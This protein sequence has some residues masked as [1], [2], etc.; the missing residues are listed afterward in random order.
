MALPVTSPDDDGTRAR[1]IRAARELRLL[2]MRYGIAETGTQRLDDR[3][4]SHRGRLRIIGEQIAELEAEKHRLLGE[5]EG[6]EKALLLARTS[7][8]E[9]LRQAHAEAWSPFGIRAY[10]VWQIRAGRLQGLR[11]IWE[12]PELTAECGRGAGRDEVPHSDGRCGPPACGIYAAKRPEMLL[13]SFSLAFAGAMGLVEL[14]GKVVEHR[15]GYRAL[16]AHVVALGLIDGGRWLATDD[17][18]LIAAAFGD[19]VQTLARWGL[20]GRTLQEPWARITEY[21]IEREA[22]TWTSENNSA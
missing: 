3:V 12:Q 5:M 4:R 10:R 17:A 16:H 8:I 2:Q 15:D 11:V 18:E 14:T 6:F 9:H 13:R 7:E 20:L 21:L 1:A 19:P 22:G